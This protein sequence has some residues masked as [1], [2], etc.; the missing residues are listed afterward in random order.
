VTDVDK[1]MQVAAWG[2]DSQWW[3]ESEGMCG[4]CALYTCHDGRCVDDRHGECALCPERG[5]AS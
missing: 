4:G 3:D 1:T 2:S 5:G